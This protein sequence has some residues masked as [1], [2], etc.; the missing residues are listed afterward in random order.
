MNNRPEPVHPRLA[1]DE[2]RGWWRG[3]QPGLRPPE[4]R[5]TKGTTLNGGGVAGRHGRPPC[6]G[7]PACSRSWPLTSCSPRQGPL[8]P[9]DTVRPRPPRQAEAVRPEP[10][11]KAQGKRYSRPSTGP[12][13]A[14]GLMRSTPTGAMTM[15]ST[16]A[17]SGPRASPRWSPAVAPNMAPAW[18]CTAGSSS[19]RSCYCTG[20]G[21]CASAGRSATTSTRRSSALPAALPAGAA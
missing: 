16:A 14:S 1:R 7:N 5:E 10:G 11:P 21:G 12:P 17:K 6:A 4:G 15:T 20:S 19:S 2:R 3:E 9:A 8:H 13:S 18:A